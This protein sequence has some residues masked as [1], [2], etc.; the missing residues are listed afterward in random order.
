M[1]NLNISEQAKEAV[2]TALGSE[3][4]A[5][6]F[7]LIGGQ[8]IGL[9]GYESMSSG[10]I[11]DYV[12]QIGDI[13][14]KGEKDM[15]IL[16]ALSI[17]DVMKLAKITDPKLATKALANV[18]KQTKGR[19]DQNMDDARRTGQ[20][21]AYLY[22]GKGFKLHIGEGQTNGR[23]LIGGYKISKK[24]IVKGTFKADTRRE[25]TKVQDTIKAKL[26][27]YKYRSFA[28]D[29]LDMVHLAGEKVAV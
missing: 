20:Y 18:I 13:S 4:A 9:K 12:I 3:G 8:F 23:L 29:N 16:N 11:A 17:E 25:L 22:L 10:E 19:I 2:I 21:K 26:K 6:V 5:K 15:D 1:P 14:A 28:I 24:T 27:A 7:T